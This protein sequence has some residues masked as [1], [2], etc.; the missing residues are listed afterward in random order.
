[1]YRIKRF[2]DEQD[3]DRLEKKPDKSL[4]NTTKEPTK[5]KKKN[6]LKNRALLYGSLAAMGGLRGLGLKGGM[7]G[8]AAGSMV[9]LAGAGII[10]YAR[11]Y[12]AK[13]KRITREELER[14]GKTFS[15]F[16]S[17]HSEFTD[18][19]I[20]LPTGILLKRTDPIKFIQWVSKYSAKI[21]KEIDNVIWYNAYFGADQVGEIQINITDNP[22]EFHLGWIGINEGHRNHG[23]AT[24]ILEY[25]IQEAKNK[26][27]QEITLEATEMGY[28]IY[29]KLGF[30][31]ISVSRKEPSLFRRFLD[32][33]WGSSDQDDELIDMKLTLN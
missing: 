28:P 11:A 3:Y 33:C 1:M 30:K 12:R 24:K 8:V 26:G 19:E 7:K 14:R 31:E 20:K 2:S 27:Y 5:R 16:F 25:F 6:Q 32:W 21:R 9:G 4:D 23:Y 15:K 10:D 29:K 17:F 18:P 13:R 22:G